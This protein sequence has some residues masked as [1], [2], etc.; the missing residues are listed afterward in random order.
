MGKIGFGVQF[1]Q[2]FDAFSDLADV[3]E[4]ARDLGFSSAWIYDHLYSVRGKPGL[5]GWTTLAALA[6]TTEKIRIGVLV[7]CNSFRHPPLLAKMATT[8]DVISKGRLEFGIGAGWYKKEYIPY[9]IPYP[10]FN[11]RLAQLEEALQVLQSMWLNKRATFQGRHYQIHGVE[12][13]PRAYQKPHP[14]IWIGGNREEILALAARYGNALNMTYINPTDSMANLELLKKECN[15]LGRDFSQ[16]IKSWH[17]PLY[18]ADNPQSLEETALRKKET[19]INR[20]IRS[21]TN[22]EYFQTILLGTPDQ[23]IRRIQEY[24]DTG[25]NYFILSESSA[26]RQ[27]IR[28]FANEVMPSFT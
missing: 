24:I 12:L 8:I 3:F 18:L 5:E 6:A 10:D 22:E 26:L 28:R 11:T 20:R 15:R 17:G 13:Q 27:E 16:L 4:K 7:T 21:L 9:G 2:E 19:S 23:C 1:K 14:P 25:I